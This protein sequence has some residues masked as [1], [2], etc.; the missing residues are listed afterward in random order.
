MNVAMFLWEGTPW[1]ASHE[2]IFPALANVRGAQRQVSRWCGDSA[3]LGGRLESHAQW[4][5]GDGA[6]GP[7]FFCPVACQ[8]VSREVGRGWDGF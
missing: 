6:P 5:C 7:D 2:D 8:T 3:S 4:G 1:S